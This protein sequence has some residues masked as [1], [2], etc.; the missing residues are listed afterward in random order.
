LGRIRSRIG[1]EHQT[2]VVWLTVD[3]KPFAAN[4]FPLI[5]NSKRLAA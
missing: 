2:Q 5:F 4:L 1:E 3:A